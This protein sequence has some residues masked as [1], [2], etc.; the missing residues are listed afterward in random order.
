[1]IRKLIHFTFAVLLTGVVVAQDVSLRS[2][3]P[4]RYVVVKGDT[5]WDIAGRFLDKPWQWPAIWQANPQIENP[6]LIYPGD[7]VSLVYIDGVPQLR[8]SRGDSDTA[9]GSPVMPPRDN[10]VKLSPS[11]RI[12]DKTEPINAIPLK[13]IEP[14]LREVRVVSPGE[15]DTLPYIVANQDDKLTAVYSDKVYARGLNASAGEEFVVA[16]LYSIYDK[17]GDEGDVRRVLPEQHWKKAPN[18]KNRNEGLWNQTLPWNHRPRN[19]VGY[20]LVGVS[21]VRVTRSGEISELDVLRDRTEIK[22]GDVIL[23]LDEKAF[24]DTFFPHAMDSV[25]ANFRILA[26]KD[27]LYG[28]GQYQIVALS[29]GTN[30]GVE[31]GHVFS[32]FRPGKTVDDRVGYRYGSFARESKVTLP[33]DYHGLVMVFRSFDNISYAMVMSG[34]NLVREYDWV[35]H[36]D[37]RS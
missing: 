11:I 5:L 24:D 35:R 15:Y 13:S 34:G 16:R 19:P 3:H 25:P 1:V 6:H 4:D 30:Q 20:E 26:T 14:F 17:V 23:P 27:A 37:E 29:G 10:T 36:P 28:V 32:I 33:D 18:V 22:E 9:G 2:D 31:S 12:L 7:V 8:L 21:H